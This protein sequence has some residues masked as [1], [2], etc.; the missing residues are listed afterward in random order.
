MKLKE[1]LQW[2]HQYQSDPRRSYGEKRRKSCPFKT[3]L[4]VNVSIE[5]QKRNTE[6]FSRYQTHSKDVPVKIPKLPRRSKCLR[7]NQ[8]FQRHSSPPCVVATRKRIQGQLTPDISQRP[9][10][11]T[12]RPRRHHGVSNYYQ[13]SGYDTNHESMG[14]TTFD[15]FQATFLDPR[16]LSIANIESSFPRHCLA[17][18]PLNNWPSHALPPNFPISLSM[19]NLGVS[20]QLSSTLVPLDAHKA[21]IC[22]LRASL[23][24][25]IPITS[26][27]LDSELRAPIALGILD[28]EL[29]APYLDHL[30]MDIPS[31]QSHF[32]APQATSPI[33]LGTLDS[34]LRAPYLDHLSMDIPSRQSHFEAPQATSPI[35]L[36]TL[37]SELR[38]P[39]LDHFPT[40][41]PSRQSQF[42]ALQ[43]TLPMMSSVLDSGLPAL[44][45]GDFPADVSSRNSQLETSQANYAITSSRQFP[46]DMHSMPSQLHASPTSFYHHVK[47]TSS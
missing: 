37:D 2:N 20:N 24:A 43:T 13:V 39:Y 36:G 42:K 32:E 26:S 6:W 35:A 41:I 22:D 15:P 33:A 3:M 8:E 21:T 28:S 7:A 19:P 30:S 23:D 4:G 31:R 34:E 45:L 16:P 12:N 44:Y 11:T 27:G 38:A 25:N 40:D 46:A 29:R 1:K 14:T 5:Y 47:H 18:L 17:H 9:M 10:P